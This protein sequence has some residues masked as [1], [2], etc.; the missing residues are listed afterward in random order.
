MIERARRAHPQL[1]FVH[2][3]AQEFTSGRTL[4][5]RRLVGSDS[6][7]VGSGA[8]AAAHTSRMHAAHASHSEFLQPTL[9]GASRSRRQARLGAARAATE[10]VYRRRQCE[11]PRHRRLRS[12][13]SLARDFAPTGHTSPRLAGEPVPRQAVGG[14]APRAHQF[15]DRSARHGARNGAAHGLDRRRRT[16]RVGEHR[17]DFSTR[18]A[19]RLRNRADL[20]R[21]RVERWDVRGDPGGDRQ[22]S[23]AQSAPLQTIRQRAR[24]TPFGVGSRRLV[25]TF[26]SSSMPT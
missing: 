10:L 6:R 16:K 12:A 24:A 18:A 1:R 20:R 11:P 14:Q 5:L 9:G 2:A 7:R 8:R 21:R 3:D 17:G 22:A 13:A 23:R 4:R 15:R 26:S 25:G 19:A